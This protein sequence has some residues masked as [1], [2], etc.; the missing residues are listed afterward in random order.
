MPI[1]LLLA[2]WQKVDN[3][4]AGTSYTLYRLMVVLTN[5][6]YDHRYRL[7]FYNSSGALLDFAEVQVDWDVDIV[8]A[9]QTIL[10]EYVLTKTAPTGTS[11]LRVEGYASGDWLKL[12]NLCLTVN[13]T[14]NNLT[15][16]GTIG[17]NQVLC[18]NV[19]STPA[20]LTSVTC[21]IRW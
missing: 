11:Y 1:A 20:A 21:T 9:G 8:P 6:V 5:P 16:G 15:S 19:S 2:M 18:K 13:N 12:D 3:I 4:T 7:A 14:C 10:K 17:S